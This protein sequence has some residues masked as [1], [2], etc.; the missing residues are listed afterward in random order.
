MGSM[1]VSGLLFRFYSNSFSIVPRRIKR[2]LFT[3][4]GPKLSKKYLNGLESFKKLPFQ[5]LFQKHPQR[6]GMQKS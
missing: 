6:L 1:N 3:P 5:Q 4:A 2:L